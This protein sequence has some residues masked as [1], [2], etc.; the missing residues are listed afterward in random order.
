MISKLINKIVIYQLSVGK[1]M[2]IELLANVN[3]LFMNNS[4]SVKMCLCSTYMTAY[5]WVFP[6]NH[7]LGLGQKR[8]NYVHSF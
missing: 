2:L 7:L 8:C 3:L 4:L 6:K 1:T 5:I